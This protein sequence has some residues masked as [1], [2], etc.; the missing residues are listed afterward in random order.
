MLIPLRFY[1]PENPN[2]YI[3][4]NQGA[5]SATRAF[6]RV[7][8]RNFRY[9]IAMCINFGGLNNN[10]LGTDCAA[11]ETTLAAVKKNSNAWH[12]AFL[13]KSVAA[14]KKE[15]PPALRDSAKNPLTQKQ[16]QLAA[17]S[18]GIIMC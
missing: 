1:G 4:A 7:F 12:E 2:G 3:W 18:T 9:F 11:Q 17:A 15:P 5:G 14:R 6:V 16:R 10:F 13:Q 8:F